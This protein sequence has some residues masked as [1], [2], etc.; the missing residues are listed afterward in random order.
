MN[1]ATKQPR[2]LPVIGRNWSPG[3]RVQISTALGHYEHV[4]PRVHLDADSLT[5]QRVLLAPEKPRRGNG[6]IRSAL[7]SVA[8]FGCMAVLLFIQA[9]K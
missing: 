5:V 8:M 4:N 1:T 7:L 6:L 2:A 9:S 3:E